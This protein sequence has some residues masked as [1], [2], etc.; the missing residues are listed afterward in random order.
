LHLKAEE[1]RTQL[2]KIQQ[3]RFKNLSHYFPFVFGSY[4]QSSGYELF[5]AVPFV[6]LINLRK[7]VIAIQCTTMN[8]RI[9][10]AFSPNT[11][12]QV[13][14]AYQ[15]KIPAR[16]A[17]YAHAKDFATSDEMLLAILKAF[18]PLPLN[19]QQTKVFHMF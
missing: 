17:I 16:N 5:P 19:K 2:Y 18:I 3:P 4:N 11:L 12:L 9:M 8:A 1:H 14:S 10:Y 7:F 15:E 13:L 6:P